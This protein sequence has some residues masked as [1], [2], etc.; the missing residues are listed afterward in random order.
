M[1][2]PVWV[3]SAGPVV[4]AAGVVDLWSVDIL[5]IGVIGHAGI[6]RPAFC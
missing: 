2:I 3:S 4:I 6:A 5:E 1:S